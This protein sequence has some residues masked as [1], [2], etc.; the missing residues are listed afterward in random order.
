L[1]GIGNGVQVLHAANT[2]I[3]SL[4][5]LVDTAKSIANQALQTRSDIPQVDVSATI[6]GATDLRGTTLSVPSRPQRV[7]LR[8]R[9]RAN[10]TDLGGGLARAGTVI[11]AGTTSASL[12]NGT[13]AVAGV[14]TRSSHGGNSP[15]TADGHL[16]QRAPQRDLPRRRRGPPPPAALPART[17]I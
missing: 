6:T 15:S 5:K 11:N 9:R 10:A 16:C 12:L 1:D 4:Q 2:G 14:I 13:A 17:A 7:V 8:R 3:T